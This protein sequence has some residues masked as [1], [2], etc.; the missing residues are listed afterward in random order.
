LGGFF[1]R[2]RCG[3]HPARFILPS[4]LCYSNNGVE[5]WH[6]ITLAVTLILL[7]PNERRDKAFQLVVRRVY[8]LFGCSC[9]SYFEKVSTELHTRRVLI[10]IALQLRNLNFVISD[11]HI[12]QLGRRQ[13]DLPNYDLDDD[14]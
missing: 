3:T 9:G 12:G 7:K 8:E 5:S 13:I 1:W 14:Q 10:E 11:D 4:H 2:L 6:C